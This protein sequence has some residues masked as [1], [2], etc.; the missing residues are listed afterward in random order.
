[1]IY[2]VICVYIYIWLYVY[3]IYI[4]CIIYNMHFVYIYIHLYTIL[5]DNQ[6]CH[7]STV[8]TKDL[9]QHREKTVPSDQLQK[10]YLH[11][12][13]FV[14]VS[15]SPCCFS[16]PRCLLDM[17]PSFVNDMYLGYDGHHI[18]KLS[19]TCYGGWGT[20]ELGSCPEPGLPGL[21]GLPL[22]PMDPNRWV[23]E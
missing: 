2:I 10:E 5:F 18:L 8:E 16:L 6:D 11:D 4:I 14:V 19:W 13:I 22:L 15:W 23:L 7:T 17:N 1:M 20:S 21:P 9:I 3:I 12:L